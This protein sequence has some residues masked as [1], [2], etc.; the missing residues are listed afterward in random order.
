MNLEAERK[1]KFDRRMEGRPDW[2]GEE[3][4]RAELAALPDSADKIA[5][6]E[7]DAEEP[8]AAPDAAP[9]I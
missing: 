9:E 4:F 7:D 2:A 5:E 6:D 3:E 1:L 8:T